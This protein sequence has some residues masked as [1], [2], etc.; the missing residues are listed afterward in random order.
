MMYQCSYCEVAFE[1]MDDPEILYESYDLHDNFDC[2]NCGNEE[3]T[4]VEQQW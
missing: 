4:V 2:P 3:A 1:S